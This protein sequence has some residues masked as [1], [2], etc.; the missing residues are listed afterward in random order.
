[1]AIRLQKIVRPVLA[2][3]CLL[4]AGL[5]AWGLW[6]WWAAPPALPGITLVPLPVRLGIR[7]DTPRSAWARYVE[8]GQ[9]DGIL[10]HASGDV[11]CDLSLWDLADAAPGAPGRLWRTLPVHH[12]GF[13]PRDCF[14]QP[15]RSRSEDLLGVFTADGTP[16]TTEQRNR[17]AD[18]KR[19]GSW[20]FH[21][22]PPLAPGETRPVLFVTQTASP[23]KKTADGKGW[24]LAWGGWREGRGKKSRPAV[25]LRAL[26]LPRDAT[27]TVLKGTPE[28]EVL[29]GEPPVLLWTA[30]PGEAL[31]PVKLTV[32]WPAP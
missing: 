1:M 6:H 10:A 27:W 5:T 12:S 16:L 7:D 2:A 21:F 32:R 24:R 26:R 3:A 25:H 23:F 17:A 4:A 29:P 30:G 15:A 11:F 13:A 9:R 19:G 28:P 14:E 22:K 20:L 18:P 8:L 31:P